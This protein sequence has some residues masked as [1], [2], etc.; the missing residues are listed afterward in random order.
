MLAKNN[1]ALNTSEK[2]DKLILFKIFL[3]IRWRYILLLAIILPV[4]NACSNKE[5]RGVYPNIGNGG[6]N[7]KLK[8]Y[9][10]NFLMSVN[11]SENKNDDIKE[12]LEAYRGDFSMSV[13]SI[14]DVDVDD[15]N[16]DD[17]D[18]N[19]NNNDDDSSID[20]A[21]G[22]K[23][24]IKISIS[25]FDDNIA[26]EIDKQ[27]LIV[28]Y[29]ADRLMEKVSFNVYLKHSLAAYGSTNPLLIFSDL[30]LTNQENN[31]SFLMYNNAPV[32]WNYRLSP[33]SARVAYLYQRLSKGDVFSMELG[34]ELPK[35]KNSNS[36]AYY[37]FSVV[38]Q[39][40][41]FLLRV[42]NS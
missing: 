42:N 28:K 16:G 32:R 12:P 7:G 33:N 26:L 20:S 13:D 29:D 36:S 31:S 17:N 27:S 39:G 6:G 9:R 15:N 37:D 23:A 3:S 19:N 1:L 22:N 24:Q 21:A 5:L 11:P 40:K 34:F 25:D 38:F 30:K 4:I 35:Y 2:T 18:D 8:T 41:K 14:K 10:G